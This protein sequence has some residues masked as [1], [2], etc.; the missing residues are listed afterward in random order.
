MV[1]FSLKDIETHGA[2]FDHKGIR[3]SVAKSL[4]KCLSELPL[5]MGIPR[6]GV[7]TA[8]SGLPDN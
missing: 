3:S 8:C 2:Y 4:E 7:K 5:V 1:D 6:Q